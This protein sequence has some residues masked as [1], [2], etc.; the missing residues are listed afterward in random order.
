MTAT[1]D[2]VDDITLALSQLAVETDAGDLPE[3][4]YAAA[5]MALLDALGC[6]YAG[7]DAPG[8]RQ[9]FELADHWGGREEATIWFHSCRLPAPEAALVNSTQLHALDYDDYHPQSNCHVTSV[10]VPAVLAAG[11]AAGASER[12]VLAALILGTEV[13]SRLGR[14]TR[15]RNRHFGFLPTSVI[16]GFGAAAAACRLSGC[17]VA[18]TVDAMGIWYAQAA[19]NRQAL[20]DRTLTKRI[21]PGFAA[22]AAVYAAALAARGFSGPHRIIGGQPASLTRLF[23]FDGGDGPPTVD[24]VMADRQTWGIEELQYKRFACCGVSDPAAGAAAA[25]AKEHGLQP[26]QVERI[27]VFGPNAAS[28]FGAVTWEEHETP[29]V[30]A[31]FCTPY[32]VAA[33]FRHHRFGP[34][35]IAPAQIAADREVAALAGRVRLCGWQEWEGPR[36]EPRWTAIRVIL[37]DGRTFRAE[38]DDSLR[39]VSPR[40]D[41]ELLAKFRSNLA[42]ANIPSAAPAGGLLDALLGFGGQTGIREFAERWLA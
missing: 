32:V 36:P 29:Q 28:P 21:Q 5:R 12:E 38:Q 33:A 6:A 11:E 19:G 2:S 31:Q 7:H 17:T 14:V 27:E 30:L 16:G 8:V 42:V 25:L 37:R 13:V 20:F 23:G 40:D 18:A 26:E 9:V 4:V 34:Q 41:G 1:H 15:A 10:L 22:K 24:E 3:R 35:E 39:F